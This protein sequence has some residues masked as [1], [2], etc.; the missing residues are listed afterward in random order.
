MLTLDDDR[1]QYCGPTPASERV[2]HQR[3]DPLVI[4]PARLQP[5]T[6]L[7]HQHVLSVARGLN[8]FDPLQID[9]ERQ[10]RQV[11]AWRP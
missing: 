1:V 10:N 5:D 9:D 8:L 4:G 11:R 6:A 7:Q 2:H 3:L